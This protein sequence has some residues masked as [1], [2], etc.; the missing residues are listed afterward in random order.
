MKS[1]P[2]LFE[3]LGQA[4]QTPRGLVVRTPDVEALRQRLYKVRGSDPDFAN[5]S[6]VVH[7]RESDILFIVKRSPDNGESK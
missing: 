4:L 1:P 2:Q 5:L 3:L 7:P 6:F